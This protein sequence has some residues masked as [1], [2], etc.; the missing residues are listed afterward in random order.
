MVT[1]VFAIIE[2]VQSRSGF[3][4]NWDPRKLRPVV[5]PSRISRKDGAIKVTMRVASRGN[6]VVHEIAPGGSTR[7]NHDLSGR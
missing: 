6:V 1:A 3:L 5:D 2:R 4:E 7:A